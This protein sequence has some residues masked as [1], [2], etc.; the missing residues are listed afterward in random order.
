MFN[1]SHL[2][3]YKI[4]AIEILIAELF[5]PIYINQL[6]FPC[7]QF[8][9]RC[10]KILNLGMKP[11]SII[12]TMPNSHGKRNGI[13]FC[14]GHLHRYFTFS[15]R[16]LLILG[17]I[18]TCRIQPEGW[19]WL[20]PL[21]SHSLA[22]PAQRSAISKLWD[23]R[24]HGHFL[25]ARGMI[26]FLSQDLCSDFPRDSTLKLNIITILRNREQSSSKV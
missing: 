18:Q 20:L 8:A 1:K 22:S 16:N 17:V 14:R 11:A 13:L 21:S 26:I 4:C 10:V 7:Y 2:I 23:S 3:C 6:F 5:M 19:E 24:F 15:S 12:C 25:T 9:T